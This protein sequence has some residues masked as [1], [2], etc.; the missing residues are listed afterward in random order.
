MLGLARLQAQDV[1]F[2]QPDLDPMLL[3][4]AYSGFYEG[5]GRFGLIYRNQW[6]SITQPYQTLALT[7]EMAIYRNNSGSQG[8]SLGA[9]M[10]ADR[11]GTLHYG[12]TSGHL[13]AAYYFALNR[14]RTNV[15][16]LG[17]S[18]GYGQSGFDPSQAELNDPSETFRQVLVNYPMVGL[19]AAWYFMP[20]ADF[21]LRLGLSANNVNRP[22]ISYL[23]ADDTYLQRRYTLFARAEWR[24]WSSLSLMP[25]VMYQLQGQYHELVYG[26]DFKWYLDEQ[27]AKPI[28]LRAGLALRQ[29]D[30]L[31]ASL[32]IEYGAFLFAFNYDANISPLA[33]ASGTVGAME[34]GLVY[35]FSNSRKRI[36]AV[37]CPVY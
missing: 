17:F 21:V 31:I 33:A 7:G 3:N 29:A 11:A 32:L 1:H 4:P 2:S 27:S 12:T 37:K 22:N 24:H 28:S 20:G 18:L 34:V 9:T 15:V 16:S 8:L 26:A 30:A 5:S 36:K 25:V 10:L 13:S 14:Y 35:R 6:F 23:G 19:G